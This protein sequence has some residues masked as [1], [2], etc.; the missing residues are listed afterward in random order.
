MPGLQNALVAFHRALAA[1]ASSRCT[2]RR[3]IFEGRKV[4][5][6]AGQRKI[7]PAFSHP[8]C[9]HSMFGV[10]LLSLTY[11]RWK[12]GRGRVFVRVLCMVEGVRSKTAS[13]PYLF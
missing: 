3:S 4:A 13:V 2:R 5:L 10:R 8:V 11:T 9:D 1:R 12:G 7:F 6:E